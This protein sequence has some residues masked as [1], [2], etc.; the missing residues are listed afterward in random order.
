MCTVCVSLMPSIRFFP[1]VFAFFAISFANRAP[2]FGRLRKIYTY[3]PTYRSLERARGIFVVRRTCGTVFIVL[4]IFYIFFIFVPRFVRSLF[5]LSQ[6]IMCIRSTAGRLSA[7]IYVIHRIMH[8]I[9]VCCCRFYVSS[10]LLFD[11]WC[12]KLDARTLYCLHTNCLLTRNPF[13]M[14][15]VHHT[16]RIVSHVDG[17]RWIPFV[18][19]KCVCVCRRRCRCTSVLC[20]NA[21]HHVYGSC[22]QSGTHKH[23][24]SLNFKLATWHTPLHRSAS[25]WAATPYSAYIRNAKAFGQFRQ[26]L[27]Q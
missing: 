11:A 6:S 19:W 24:L 25:A 16:H 13:I 1:R 5:L 10:Y 12:S 9:I 15:H 26:N 21:V 7:V 27:I 2:R 3:Q 23:T 8:I 20:T 14:S 22:F 18:R 4:H 17:K